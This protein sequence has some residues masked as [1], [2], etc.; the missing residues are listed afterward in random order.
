MCLL[1]PIG[2]SV[3]LYGKNTNPCSTNTAEHAG[4]ILFVMDHAFGSV[5]AKMARCVFQISS[6]F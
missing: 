2:T 5:R 4:H 1:A 3:N 6:V